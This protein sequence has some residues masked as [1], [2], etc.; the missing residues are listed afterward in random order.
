MNLVPVSI[1]AHWEALLD[2]GDDIICKTQFQI[3]VR[4][5]LVN[6][7]CKDIDGNNR[8][9]THRQGLVHLHSLSQGQPCCGQ[10]FQKLGTGEKMS[11]P[12]LS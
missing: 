1:R 3:E 10:L 4:A 2:R 5:S 12:C 6:Q 7:Y 11:N 9:S 8:A